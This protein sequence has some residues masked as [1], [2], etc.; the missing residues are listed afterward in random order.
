[1]EIT[2]VFRAGMCIT[3]IGPI[4]AT[5]IEQDGRWHYAVCDLEWRHEDLYKDAHSFEVSKAL[6][7]HH[8]R[9]RVA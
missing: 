5:I 3:I 1:M 9:K 4:L 7:E 8:I 6:C 2:W